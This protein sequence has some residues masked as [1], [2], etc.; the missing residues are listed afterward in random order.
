SNRRRRW[1]AVLRAVCWQVD[2]RL[3]GRP[4]DVPLPGGMRVRCY[5]DSQSATL[6]LYCHGLYDYDEM[7]FVL[8]Y[9]RP[10]DRFLDI[11]A[12]VGIYSLL[13]ASAVGPEGAVDAFEPVPATLERLRENLRLSGV[14]NIQVHPLAVGA[15]A[16]EV[17]LETGND[18][19]NHMLASSELPGSERPGLPSGEQ[20]GAQ[21]GLPSAERTMAVRCV[22]LDE[23]LPDRQYAMG[24][25]D[26]EGAELLAL[27]GARRMLAAANPPVW[28]LEMNGLCGRYGHTPAQL[29]EWLA[30][31]GYR[32]ARYDADR[33]Q[34]VY[35]DQLWTRHDNLLAVSGTISGFH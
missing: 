25:I 35:G 7:R 1:Q 5:P 22:A 16:G 28:L 30:E 8:D 12:N 21:T 2:K 20:T 34:L 6:S 24:K 17:F 33:R 27:R 19:M 29:S 11:G 4:W 15:T 32:L 31:H 3:R 26:I 14:Q 10:G 13:A 23:Y 9:L 18:A